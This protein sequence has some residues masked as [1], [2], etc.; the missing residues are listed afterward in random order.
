MSSVGQ[1]QQPC[2][3]GSIRNRW[4]RVI[5]VLVD[6]WR[7]VGALFTRRRFTHV[8]DSTA[9]CVSPLEYWEARHLI[10]QTFKQHRSTFNKLLNKQNKRIWPSIVLCL[11]G[12]ACNF[13]TLLRCFINPLESKGTYSATSNN[14]E[15]W[16]T[17]RWWVGCYVWYSE[18]RTGRGRSSPRP[19]LAVPNVPAYPSTASVSIAVCCIT[20]LGHG[21]EII[22]T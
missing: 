6:R 16:Y 11:V 12:C 21:R 9:R 18:E 20:M 15:F 14:M 4:S 19:L 10:F 17:G 8:N 2:G 5:V 1:S 3:C 13:V 22:I 7:Q